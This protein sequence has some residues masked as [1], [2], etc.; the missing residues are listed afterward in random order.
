MKRLLLIAG[1]VAMSGHMLRAA[2]AH[3]LNGTW[4][5]DRRVAVAQERTGDGTTRCFFRDQRTGANL[6]EVPLPGQIDP[7]TAPMQATWNFGGKCVVLM[8]QQQPERY[9]I[10]CFERNADGT[11][12]P[13][14]IALPDPLALYRRRTGKVLPF[15][16]GRLYSEIGFGPWESDDTFPLAL[17][18]VVATSPANRVS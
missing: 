3:T 14:L 9:A 13:L 10:C 8:I 18:K 6:G 16:S 11:F 15:P 7:R 4:S 2:P 5:P 12:R 1:L 17:G